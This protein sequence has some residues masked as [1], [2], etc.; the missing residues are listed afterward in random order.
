MFGLVNRA[1]QSFVEDS[2][3]P[4]HWDDVARLAGLE[5]RDFEGMLT[6]PDAVTDRVL[7]ACG[8][9]LGKR[10]EAL[11]EDLG[12]YLVTHPHMEVVRRLLRYGGGEFEE[13][14]LSLDELNDRVRIAIPDLEMPELT[15]RDRGNGRFSLFVGAQRTGYGALLLGLVQAMADDY[16]ALVLMELKAEPSDMEAGEHIEVELLE[17]AF[18]QGRSFDLAAGMRGA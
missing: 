4:K 7:T 17:A 13:F 10:D 15:L 3:S 5:T 18:S 8:K 14:L 16:G 6:Y 11:L 1:I 9:V 12:T 2:Y